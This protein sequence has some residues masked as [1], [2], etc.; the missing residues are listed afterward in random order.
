MASNK[1]KEL[2]SEET[3]RQFDK[4]YRKV[5]LT[6][7]QAQQGLT[8][9]CWLWQSSSDDDGYGYFRWNGELFRAHRFSYILNVGE[10]EPGKDVDHICNARLCVNPE[11]LQ[12][13][14][15]AENMR[16]QKERSGSAGTPPFPASGWRA[17]PTVADL[18]LA[19]CLDFIEKNNIKVPTIFDVGDL[20]GAPW[21]EYSDFKQYS[22]M[23]KR[24]DLTLLSLHLYAVS[25]GCTVE[26]SAA[27]ILDVTTRT[28]SRWY[29]ANADW[30]SDTELARRE[31][32]TARTS[33]LKERTENSMESRVQY[34][35]FKDLVR[36]YEVMTRNEETR[37]DR[38]AKKRDQN[39]LGG[40]PIINFILPPGVTPEDLMRMQEAA[41]QRVRDTTVDAEFRDVT[42]AAPAL[43]S[44]AQLD[45]DF[46]E[47]F[48]EEED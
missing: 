33:S 48:S 21:R 13:V 45:E 19:W 17:D 43:P 28:L 10:I 24:D 15:H 31:G 14:M 27:S 30:K 7:E 12:V 16:L 20:E 44:G 40:G 18:T 23:E 34:A 2:H 38:R 25:M 36:L 46:E 37:A 1:K 11:H 5:E 35:D 6:L 22:K 4:H 41:A 29:V 42:D 8:S 9:G 32:K 26:R 47:A 39:L 3:R